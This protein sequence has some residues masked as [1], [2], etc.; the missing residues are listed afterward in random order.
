MKISALVSYLI[1]ICLELIL[2]DFSFYSHCS[3]TSTAT[4]IFPNGFSF[5]GADLITED[6]SA[7]AQEDYIL[8]ITRV[9]IEAGD[10]YVD[11][12]I[13][14]IDDD[15][16]E[17]TEEFVV[18]AVNPSGALRVSPG[19]DRTTVVIQDNDKLKNGNNNREG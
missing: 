5:F 7:K 2:F 8:N 18:R 11:I 4:I 3:F 14:I 12:P 9:T 1:L 6:G 19:R 17:D 15:L 13:Y 16:N 10:T